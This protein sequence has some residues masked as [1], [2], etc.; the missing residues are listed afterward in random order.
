MKK[1]LSFAMLLGLVLSCTPAQPEAVNHS[2]YQ[3]TNPDGMEQV[4]EFLKACGTYYIATVD[5]DQAR[6]RPFGTVN[7]FEGKL[8]IQTGHSKDVAKQIAANGKVELCAYNGS[9]WLRLSGTLVDD[10][11]VE[12]KKAMLDA[13]PSLRG[14]Y[15][16]NDENTA[17]FYF[18][19]ARAR[20]CS[21]VNPEVVIEF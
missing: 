19:N 12:A 20:L 18:T 7:V 2:E 3:T 5:V 13:Y 4:Y 11:R 15:N 6:V 21:F 9:Q 17:V 10:E 14:M 8:Y 16:E 1:I